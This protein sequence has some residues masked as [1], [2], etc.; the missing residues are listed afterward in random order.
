MARQSLREQLLE[1]GVQTLHRVGFGAASV[2]DITQAAGVPLGTFTNHFASKEQFAVAVLE[3]YSDR[4]VARTDATL[5]NPE[6]EPRRRLD[7]YFDVIEDAFRAADWRFGCLIPNMALELSEHSEP[8]RELL[9]TTLAEQRGLFAEALSETEFAS[10]SSNPQETLDRA[11]VIQAA[12]H[13][14]LMQMKVERNA[15]PIRRF[16]RVLDLLAG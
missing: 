12:W 11:G 15:E 16:R 3:R 13:G 5:R 6:L 8:L 2:R 14:T 1:S 10:G 7:A 4:L 9:L